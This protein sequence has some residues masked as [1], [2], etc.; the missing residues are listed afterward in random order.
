E[1]LDNEL[2]NLKTILE[3]QENKIG[4]F[5]RAY[6]GELPQQLEPNLR[7][8]DRF[9]ADLQSIQLSKKM[10]EDRKLTVEKTIEIMKQQMAGIND[11]NSPQNLGS[12]TG[13]SPLMLKLSQRREILA[14]LQ[15]E[16]K[17]SYPDIIMLKREIQEIENQI[18]LA[19]SG[20]PLQEG[21]RESAGKVFQLAPGYLADLQ[22]QLRETEIELRGLRNREKAIEKQI[23]VYEHRVENV[24]AREQ[25]LLTLV[26]DYDNTKKNY[27][28]LLDKKLSAKISENLEKRQ[29]GEQFRILDAANLPER[30]FKPDRVKIGLAGLLLGLGGGLALAFFREQLDSSIRKPEEVERVTS[31]PVLVS[32]PDFTEEMRGFEKRAKKT[33]VENKTS[34]E[35]AHGA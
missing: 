2:S 28:A 32:I 23:K 1:F 19:E 34:K 21:G 15:M 30:P 7:A 3:E 17:E 26:R 16:Y 11:P 35:E 29:K 10:A 6:M 22:K 27:E 8:L 24:P 12:E 13:L 5:K 20:N 25:I 14:S 33:I 9:Q 31:V 18:G 4:E